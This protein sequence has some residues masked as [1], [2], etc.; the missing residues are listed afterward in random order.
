[1]PDNQLC[2]I[3]TRQGVASRPNNKI[4]KIKIIP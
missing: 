2:K 3:T 1:M 4:N